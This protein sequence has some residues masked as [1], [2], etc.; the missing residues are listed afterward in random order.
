MDVS[1]IVPFYNSSTTLVRSL[2]SLAE[3]SLRDFEIICVDDGSDDDSVE[4]A[5]EWAEMHPEIAFRL[6][7]QQNQGPGVARNQGIAHAKGRFLC[8]LDADDWAHPDMLRIAVD[9]AISNDADVVIWKAK[10]FS[11]RYSREQDM[12]DDVVNC[13]GFG[14]PGSVFSWK[15]NP[16]AIFTSFQNWP[17]NKLFSRSFVN[18]NGIAFAEIHRGE[19]LLFTGAALVLADKIVFLEDRLVTYR[20]HN[21]CSA[22]ATKDLFPDDT[23]D[24]FV[25]FKSFLEKVGLYESVKE[26]YSNWAISGL[27]SSLNTVGSRD[28]YYRLCTMAFDGGLE[29][30]GV[31][32]DFDKMVLADHLRS[33]YSALL[34]GGADGYLFYRSRVLNDFVEDGQFQLAFTWNEIRNLNGSILARDQEIDAFYRKVEALERR[35]ESLEAS[36]SELREEH[37][38]VMNA[39]EQKVGRILCTLPRA[40]QRALI[41]MRNGK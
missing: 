39:A 10:Y 9:A 12:P 2:D 34:S 38:A 7:R 19:D 20:I 23:F 8:F 4:R 16:K 17:W 18:E 41:N 26:S 5:T 15:D 3:Q 1:V 6:I 28:A 36:L 14:A 30:M 11:D 40:L 31:G 13:W 35:N 27:M 32:D 22:M 37:D 21:S 33:D 25:E 24:S 29:R